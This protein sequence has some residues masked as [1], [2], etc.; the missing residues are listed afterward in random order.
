MLFLGMIEAFRH[1]SEA[2]TPFLAG[3]EVSVS[4]FEPSVVVNL[5]LYGVGTHSSK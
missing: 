2:S 1:Q 3:R 4:A 5:F